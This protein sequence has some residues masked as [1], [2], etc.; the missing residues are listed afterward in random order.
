MTWVREQL[1]IAQNPSWKTKINLNSVNAGWWPSQRYGWRR[2]H[3]DKDEMT[4]P[5]LPTLEKTPPGLL[6]PPLPPRPISRDFSI[7]T[8]KRHF[9]QMHPDCPL[10][11]DLPCDRV[12]AAAVTSG[13]GPMTPQELKLKR[14][15][16][17]D[18]QT[19]LLASPRFPR[20][21]P[22]V[23]RRIPGGESS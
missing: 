10:G 17:D 6:P 3:S 9:W 22:H 15:N 12:E 20:S 16:E 19:P 14:W 21:A 11:G 5:Q 13:Q 1:W 7:F 4:F 8:I 2:I 18:V 23:S